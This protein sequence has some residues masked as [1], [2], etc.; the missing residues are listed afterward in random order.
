MSL[1]NI[2]NCLFLIITFLSLFHISL[3]DD[4]AFM[5]YIKS[6]AKNILLT[7]VNR[8]NLCEDSLYSKLTEKNNQNFINYLINSSSFECNDISSYYS[9]ISYTENNSNY[10]ILSLKPKNSTSERISGNYDQNYCVRGICIYNDSLTC[11]EDDFIKMINKF[12]NITEYSTN[13]TLSI[14]N[15][16]KTNKVEKTFIHYFLLTLYIILIVI[17]IIFGLFTTLPT[18]LF[19]FCFK[20][21]KNDENSSVRSSTIDKGNLYTFSNCFNIDENID[22]FICPH[23]YNKSYGSIGITNDEGLGYIKGIFGCFIIITLFG[24]LYTQLMSEPYKDY[25]LNTVEQMYYMPLKC[26]INLASRYGPRILFSCSGYLLMYKM[27]C[28]LENQITGKSKEN[29]NV[30]QNN[31]HS[32][33]DNDLDENDEEN[34]D[35][36]DSFD[37]PKIRKISGGD[38]EEEIDFEISKN[39]K[40]TNDARKRGS[41]IRDIDKLISGGFH[42]IFATEKKDQ[43][44][45]GIISLF[46]FYRSQIYKF[47]LCIITIFF[48]KYT[49]YIIFEY[50][51]IPSPSMISLRTNLID[52][53]SNFDIIGRVFQ[54]LNFKILVSENETAN[55]VEKSKNMCVLFLFW[56]IICEIFFFIVT[57]PIIYFSYKYKKN[58]LYIFI[59]LSSV[60]IVFRIILFLCSSGDTKMYSTL[61]FYLGDYYGIFWTNPFMNY[62]Y[63]LIGC[64]FGYFYFLYQKPQQDKKW[65]ES[66]NNIVY[67]IRYQNNIFYYLTNSIVAFGIIVLIMF[68]QIYFYINNLIYGKDFGLQDYFQSIFVNYFYLIDTDLA[69]ILIHYL[70]FSFFCKSEKLLTPFLT[71]DKWEI[72]SRLYFSFMLFANFIIIFVLEK[73]ETKI[74][75]QLFS[76]VYYGILCWFMLFIIIFAYFVVLEFPLKRISHFLC[77]KDDDESN[78]M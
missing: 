77:H 74:R 63:Y 67:F 41:T 7:N 56:P 64:V 20:K 65:L 61:Y 9:C 2:K 16:K 68:E 36:E 10:Y 17:M 45:V 4:S 13:K 33:N 48:V 12:A 42:Q 35:S 22:Y 21:R 44:T 51:D 26:L 40:K 25:D 70:C 55:A 15:V 75:I 69:I 78:K 24:F 6:T 58:I 59:I 8:S 50:L 38:D 14:V 49:L 72:Y 19:Q 30:E 57:V 37:V 66:S 31:I 1:Q 43:G 11:D 71:K 29:T 46:Y 27:N 53:I 23:N 5:S 28:F 62:S 73:S 32:L 39:K 3:Q 54:Y 76:I 34:E 52:Q 47:V 18:L 60:F